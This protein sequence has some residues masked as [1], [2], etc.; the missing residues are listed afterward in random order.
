M[1]SLPSLCTYWVPLFY[2]C[3][4]KF[5]QQAAALLKDGGFVCHLS[6]IRRFAHSNCVH[7]YIYIYIYIYINIYIIH[8]YI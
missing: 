5:L 6:I 1:N 4:Y 2:I 7:I 8:I 3:G